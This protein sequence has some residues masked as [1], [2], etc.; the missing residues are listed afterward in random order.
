MKKLIFTVVALLMAGFTVSAQEKCLSPKEVSVDKVKSAVGPAIGG[1]KIIKV[2]PSPIKGLYEVVIET[3][4]RVIPIYVDCTLRYLISGEIID[5]KEK[6]SLTRERV[7]ELAEE[8]AKEK[9]AQ[10]EKILGKEKAEKLKKA[11]GDR[12]YDIKI[13]DLKKLPK[14]H[15]ITYGN[16]DAELT[17]YVITDPECPYCARFDKEMKKVLKNRKDVKF[18]VVLFPLPFHKHAQK[19]S[20][21]IV[22]EKSEK[23]KKEILQQSF[24]AVNNKEY[25][26]LEKLGKECEEGKKAIDKHLMFGAQSGIGGTPAIIFPHGIVVSGWMPADQINKVLDALK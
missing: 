25:S 15:L 7:R 9:I 17:V 5:I 18:E 26:K 11:L 1:A 22:C 6:R 23:K 12:L 16:P 20:Q 10:L 19:I 13:V 2:S 3:R 21:R 8:Q 4:G 14:E 24:D